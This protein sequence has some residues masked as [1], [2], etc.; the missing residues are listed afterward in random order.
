MSPVDWTVVANRISFVPIG[1]GRPSVDRR[2]ARDILGR[3][4]DGRPKAVDVTTAQLAAR[5]SPGTRAFRELCAGS[6]F[7]RVVLCDAPAD[8]PLA[9]HACGGDPARVVARSDIRAAHAGTGG[10]ANV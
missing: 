4:D 7:N 9:A 10:T 6:A 2:T 1:F 5:L 3:D 8:E